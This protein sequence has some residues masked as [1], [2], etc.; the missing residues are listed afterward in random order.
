VSAASF[1]VVAGEPSGDLLAAELVAALRRTPALEGRR[2]APRFFGAGGPQMA[3]AGVELAFD[4]TE[5]AVVGLAEV[6]RHYGQLRRR[7][8]Q[9]VALACER[10]P[11]VI[12]CVD[13]HGFNGRLARA[14]RDRR[15]G[16][17][18]GFRNWRPKIVQYVSP[19]VWASRPGRAY[20]MARDLDRLLC[21]FPFEPPWY[22]RRVPK[23]RAE[24][25]GHPICERYGHAGPGGTGAPAA[26]PDPAA[27]V[28]RVVLFPGSRERELK[29]HLPMLC[30]VAGAMAAAVDT[31]V[32]E[33]GM[34]MRALR[35]TLVVPNERMAALAGQ[36]AAAA[37]RRMHIV[38]RPEGRGG[39]HR[40]GAG[41][42]PQLEIQVGGLAQALGGADLA[43]TKSGTITL[44]CA[45]FGVPAVV[46]YRTSWP[47]YL[48]A[49]QVAT[50]RHLAMPNLLAG[51]TVYPEFIQGRATAWNIERA[52][53][54]LLTD[55]ECRQ[56]VKN[57][58]AAVMRC[59]GGPGA[60]ERAAAAIAGLLG[61]G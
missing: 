18:A 4:L 29:A 21:L 10:Q 14:L 47:T 38:V 37:A 25:V 1:M 11:E 55:P 33:T 16:Q 39:E 51:E 54:M 30:E 58:L 3:A 27:R 17:A 6:L 12:V 52:A 46:F 9:L 35:W 42:L 49:K 7:F 24:F 26:A 44:E 36:I 31:M 56:Q 59:L 53:W 15:A 41:L 43:I 61:R 2:F 22:A 19:Q 8:R 5:D 57:K 20:G 23:L 60:S 50:V 40:T 45:Y 32:S 13:F 28:W 48:A 34:P